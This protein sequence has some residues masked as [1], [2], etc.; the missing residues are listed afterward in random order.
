MRESPGDTPISRRRLLGGVG[1][2]GT[3]GVLTG[4]TTAALFS[5]RASFPGAQSGGELELELDCPDGESRCVAS[6]TDGAVSVG[7]DDIRPGDHDST[8][9]EL[10]VRSNDGWVWLRTDCPE[11]DPLAETLEVTI[12]ETPV[13]SETGRSLASGTLADVRRELAGGVVLDGHFEQTGTGCFAADEPFCLEIEYAL[14]EDVGE[15]LAGRRSSL[16]L[17]LYA[18]QCRHNDDPQ[19]P[20]DPAESCPQQECRPCLADVENGAERIDSATFGYE[21]P[22]DARVVIVR[23]STGDDR[24]DPSGDTASWSF[25]AVADGDELD[26]QFDGRGRPDFDVYVDDEFVGAFHTSCS[27]DFCP[28]MGFGD[29]GGRLT[30]LE[31]TD[32]AGH[33]ICACPEDSDR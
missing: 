15:H 11:E 26:V 14:P 2:V 28:G 18:E 22:D 8:R 12:S 23:Q 25:D 17:S 32:R 31:A 24:S 21:G 19:N 4:S 9:I 13:C 33:E 7:F 3:A 16:R 30:I 20:F 10:T 6:D 1:I 5:E 27:A 29:G